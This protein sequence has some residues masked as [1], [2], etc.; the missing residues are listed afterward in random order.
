[1]AGAL[2]E[3]WQK[4][5]VDLSAAVIIRP[6]GVAAYDVRTVTAFPDEPPPS[7]CV[8]GFKPQ[9]LGAIAPDLEPRLGPETVLVSMLAGVEAATLRTLFPSVGSIVRIMPNLPVADRQGVTALFSA[10]ADPALRQRMQ[11]L[12]GLL[13]HATWTE[14]ESQLAAIGSL[15]GAGPA[16]VA[17]FVAALAKAGIER[18]LARDLAD[19]IALETV[20]G[21]AAMAAARGEAM[22]SVA[23]RVASPNGTTEAGLAVLDEDQAL[24]RLV[25]RTL[26]AASRRGQEL[27]EAARVDSVKALS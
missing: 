1:M 3:G 9:M 24:D 5:G 11:D 25:A 13:G 20:L 23:K 4:A 14:S 10:D 26:E 21:T 18:G 7:R 15:A 22:G 17:R 2:I 19:R 6:S 12:F 16:Y 27:A 8:L